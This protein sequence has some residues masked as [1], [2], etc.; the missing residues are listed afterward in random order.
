MLKKKLCLKQRWYILLIIII[1][2]FGEKAV[3]QLGD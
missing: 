3:H 1:L 2:T